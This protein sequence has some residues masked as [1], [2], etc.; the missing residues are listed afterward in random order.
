MPQRDDGD[1]PVF[2]IAGVRAQCRL[3]PKEVWAYAMAT[4]SAYNVGAESL[5]TA[6]RRLQEVDPIAIEVR[7]E[8][9]EERTRG[10]TANRQLDDE[11]P[12]TGSW[13]ERD[14]LLHYGE[15]IYVPI[16][17]NARME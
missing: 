8:A 16:G 17:D 14:G 6:M 5:R 1:A 13:N 3:L 11:E 12:F 9:R 2:Q 15:R 4:E 10:T 7:R